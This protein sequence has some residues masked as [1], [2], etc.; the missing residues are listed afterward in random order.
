MQLGCVHEPQCGWTRV[1][2]LK[3]QNIG[4][5]HKRLEWNDGIPA[6]N[7]GFKPKAIGFKHKMLGSSMK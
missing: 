4:F 3:V 1:C 5:W 6:W 7:N 2:L